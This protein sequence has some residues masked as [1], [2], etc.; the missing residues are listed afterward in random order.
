MEF[1]S[2]KK[3]RLF[4]LLVFIILFNWSLNNLGVI[5]QALLFLT[6]MMMPI[7]VGIALVF[8]IG[9]FVDI[10]E[11]KIFK[12]RPGRDRYNKWRRVLSVLSSVVLVI[13]FTVIVLVILIPQIILALQNLGEQMPSMAKRIEH[14]ISGF[15]DKYPEMSHNLGIDHLDSTQITNLISG[16]LTDQLPDA[17]GSIVSI[18]SSV[19][20]V[21]F[22]LFVGL[23][24]AIYV[25]LQRERILK[26]LHRLLFAFTNKEFTRRTS[27]LFV[28]T[29]SAIKNFVSGQF[30]EVINMGILTYLGM[31]VFGIP[32][33]LL[34][35]FIIGLMSLVPL[36]GSIIGVG[37]G[38]IIVAIS[39][40]S[41]AFIFLVIVIILI[42][43][44]NYFIYP[45][46]VG[47]KTGT[48]PL[49]VLLA[50]TV[51]GN[52]FGLMGM[53]VGVPLAAIIWTLLM[54]ATRSRISTKLIE[55]S[56]DSQPVRVIRTRD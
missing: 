34:V 27:K 7:L 11:E 18:T 55:D 36:F 43:I 39:D 25:L 29:A 32:S 21:V 12:F 41:K 6:R 38:F 53:I 19:F 9:V 10:L 47:G 8:I 54:E 13:G 22:N 26:G 51:F 35:A 50:V 31:L 23:I 42:Q 52:L 1:F 20:N 14:F 17:L 15:I 33:A 3:S 37:L 28:L 5:W 2:F 48:P 44:E 45:R 4:W 49:I 40:I 24:I 56:I 16:F 30:I 46:I